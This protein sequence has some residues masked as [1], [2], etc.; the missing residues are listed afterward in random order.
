MVRRKDW[1]SAGLHRLFNRLHGE[2]AL[3]ASNDLEWLCEE[4][5]AQLGPFGFQWLCACA[6][7]PA[8]RFPLTAYL[9]AELARDLGRPAPD[10]A[11]HMALCRLTWF[12]KGWMPNELRLR[13]IA[14]LTPASRAT[15][16]TSIERFFFAALNCQPGEPELDQSLDFARPPPGWHAAFRAYLNGVP[17]GALHHDVIF[18]RF[19]MGRVPRAGDLVLNRK[20]SAL[21][22]ARAAGWVSAG[23]TVALAVVI[24]LV[25]FIVLQAD[26]HLRPH[27]HTST[28]E[29]RPL[30][31]IIAAGLGGTLLGEQVVVARENGHLSIF[32]AQSDRKPDQRSL[33]GSI[34]AVEFVITGITTAVSG[35]V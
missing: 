34:D 6:V 19:M 22:G 10:E 7:Y 31:F 29:T 33:A 20:L 35:L 12:R 15:V 3:S 1:L 25:M 14:E 21:F 4:L 13:L 30:H 23:T 8:L 16:R 27:F 18:T 17:V 2:L 24:A 32:D 26:T 9:G 28:A 11:E 5:R